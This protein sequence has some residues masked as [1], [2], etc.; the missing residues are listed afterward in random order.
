VTEP[1]HFIERESSGE[2]DDLRR[3]LAETEVSDSTMDKLRESE[4]SRARFEERAHW[5]WLG[6]VLRNLLLWVGAGLLFILGV[7]DALARLFQTGGK[8]G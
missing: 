1:E 7:W 6:V 2:L 3:R 4:E 8:H 5:K